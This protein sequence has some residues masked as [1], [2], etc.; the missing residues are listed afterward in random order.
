[1]PTAPKSMDKLTAK[2]QVSRQI[3]VDSVRGGNNDYIVSRGTDILDDRTCG[4][5]FSSDGRYG[6]HERPR[7][8]H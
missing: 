1:M 4:P 5:E 3:D 7:D 8:E 6:R 2:L